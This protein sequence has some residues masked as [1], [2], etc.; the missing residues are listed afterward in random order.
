MRNKIQHTDNIFIIL[1]TYLQLCKSIS[2]LK[3][4]LYPSFP[5][6]L[7]SII[8]I[9]AFLLSLELTG[10]WVFPTSFLYAVTKVIF[11]KLIYITGSQYVVCRYLEG[12]PRTFQKACKVKTIFKI[13]DIICP[14]RCVHIYTD[15]TKATVYKT[16]DANW[17]IGTK[18]YLL[19]VV[20]FT[21]M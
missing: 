11:L 13:L 1:K 3:F 20:L 14:L 16:A 2:P 21:A 8:Q 15:G 12:F 9:E 7:H 10:V 4:H 6:H 17:S 5:F 19:L 18:P